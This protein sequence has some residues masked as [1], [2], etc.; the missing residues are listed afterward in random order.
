MDNIKIIIRFGLFHER[1]LAFHA[2]HITFAFA[3]VYPFADIPLRFKAFSDAQPTANTINNAASD[4]TVISNS[5][6]FSILMN[7]IPN[8]AVQAPRRIAPVVA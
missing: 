1:E 6:R 4:L 7:I 8:S 2:Q 5:F 3:Y